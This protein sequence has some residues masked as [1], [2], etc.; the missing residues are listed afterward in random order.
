MKRQITFK[1][2]LRTGEPTIEITGEETAYGL[3]L[4]PAIRSEKHPK[5]WPTHYAV[6]DPV[7]GAQVCIGSSRMEA[8][9]ELILNARIFGRRPGGFR[10]AIEKVRIRFY[11]PLIN[12]EM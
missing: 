3:V 7:T 12:Q 6:S 2:A 5:H 9:S 10:S 8:L 11:A 4:H 1:P